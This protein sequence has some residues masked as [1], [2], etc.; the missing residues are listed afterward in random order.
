M[1]ESKSSPSTILRRFV[2]HF[3]GVSLI[4]VVTISATA[5]AQTQPSELRK[6]RL[7]YSQGQFFKKNPEAFQRF[8]S[9]RSQPQSGQANANQSAPNPPVAGGTWQ[10]VTT[11][12]PTGSLAN[13]ILLTDG[14]VIIQRAE[15]QTWYRLTPDNTGSFVNGSWSSI[16]A[17]PGGYGPDA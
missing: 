5:F 15:T 4:A 16:A 11:L 7:S 12:A 13:P 3:I 9:T 6:P 17:M 1:G 8:L 10:T 14:T 2:S